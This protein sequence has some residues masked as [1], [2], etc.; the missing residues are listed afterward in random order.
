METALTFDDIALVP[1]FNNINSRTETHLRTWLTSKTQIEIPIVPS[2]MDTVISEELADVLLRHNSYP[3]FHRFASFE[4]QQG[5]VKKYQDRM[6]ISC[7]LSDDKYPEV[8]KLL[9]MGARGVCIDVAHGHCSRMLDMIK[10]FKRDCPDKEIIAGNV[11]TGSGVH[12]LAVAG[13]DAVKVGIGPGSACTTRKVTG[14]GVS[15][16]TAI[17]NCAVVASKM[18]IPVI[19]D[20]G[21]RGSDDIMKALAAGAS[22]VMI[23]GMF[24]KTLESAAPKIVDE[25][26]GETMVCYRGQASKEFQEDFYGRVKE[27]TV[28][29]GVAFKSRCTGT[30]DQLLNKLLGGIRSGMTY[31]GSRHIKEFHRK[32]EYVR[33]TPTFLIEAGPRMY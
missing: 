19:A 5:W 31:A 22:S 30:A 16:F 24:S 2:N 14:F 21:I 9:Q 23:G 27:N 25:T 29:E 32:V 28:P 33:V 20:G 18:R 11:C 6:Y 12:D 10:R 13:A 26:T 8:V 7:G 15:Q 17:K 1:Q 3:I 4:V